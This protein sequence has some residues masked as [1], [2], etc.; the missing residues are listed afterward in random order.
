MLVHCL[1]FVWYGQARRRATR[2]TENE[3]LHVRMVVLP[4]PGIS[5]F[6]K[7]PAIASGLL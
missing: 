1:G 3:Q 4:L 5:R 2:A 7:H 6:G